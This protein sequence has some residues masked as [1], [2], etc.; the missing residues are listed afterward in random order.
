MLSHQ[1][2]TDTH[3]TSDMQKKVEYG[4]LG[5]LLPTEVAG[6]MGTLG[7]HRLTDRCVLDQSELSACQRQLQRKD[8]V[9][10]CSTDLW[11]KGGKEHL[12][13]YMILGILKSRK[14][15]CSK[16]EPSELSFWP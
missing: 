2:S 6:H 16:M 8:P 4:F 5:K 7:C 10:Y 13:Y 1:G 3:L 12:V 14:Q 9:L 11:G 15:S